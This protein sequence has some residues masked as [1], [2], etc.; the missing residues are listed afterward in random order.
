MSVKKKCIERLWVS[1]HDDEHIVRFVSISKALQGNF[2]LQ[3]HTIRRQVRSE[4]ARMER[5]GLRRLVNS[6]TPAQ[7]FSS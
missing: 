4:I 5:K 6:R 3:M 1:G 2:F 7:S